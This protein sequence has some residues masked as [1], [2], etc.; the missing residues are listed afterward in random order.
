MEWTFNKI[1]VM[2][3]L[4]LFYGFL[5]FMILGIFLAIVFVMKE[6]NKKDDN[7]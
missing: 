7:K 5:I 3:N 4:A 1:F 6:L 2:N